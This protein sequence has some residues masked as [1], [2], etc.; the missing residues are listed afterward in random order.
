[1][2]L[3]VLRYFLT[4]AREGSVTGAANFLHVTQLTLSRQIK[5]LEEELPPRQHTQGAHDSGPDQRRPRGAR[6]PRAQ[7]HADPDG[8]VRHTDICCSFCP[9]ENLL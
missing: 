7:A 3:R 5:E 8:P 4:V 9:M 1:M 6:A 2:E